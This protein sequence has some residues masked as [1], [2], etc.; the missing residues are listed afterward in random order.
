MKKQIMIAMDAGFSG[1]KMCVNGHFVNIPFNI[2]DITGKESAYEQRIIDDKFVKGMVDGKTYTIGWVAK[3]YLANENDTHG[4]RE[5]DGFSTI[6][7]Y[8]MPIFKHALEIFISYALYQYSL[9]TKKN[10]EV[11]DFELENISEYELLVGNALPH[12]DVDELMGT[13]EEYLGR[14]KKGNHTVVLT[15][16]KKE[17]EVSYHVD[18]TLYNSQVVCTLINEAYDE[19]GKRLEG[20]TIYDNLPA[21]IIDGGYKTIGKVLF[22]RDQSIKGGVSD[23][24]YAMM[25]V[26]K[27]V[28]ERI[29]K[30]SPTFKDYMVDEWAEKGLKVRYIDSEKK[31]QQIDVKETRDEVME[32]I[33]GRYIQYLNKQHEDLL[34]VETILLGGGTGAA[35]Y[36]YILKYCKENREYIKVQ[37]AFQDERQAVNGFYGEPVY[38][39]VA[40]LY[41]CMVMNFVEED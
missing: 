35:Y 19:N 39:I 4:N 6:A 32:D 27:A 15:V 28:A 17:M 23:I 9:Y 7:R 16:G 2:V 10:N 34:D 26:N 30:F 5:M 14:K 29:S 1:D 3:E 22:R 40:G 8:K 25:N 12:S 36:Q 24:E 33:V 38:A 31:Y 21:L 13:L 18:K 41:K 11:E 20:E 37:L